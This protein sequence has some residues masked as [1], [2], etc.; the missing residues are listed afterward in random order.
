MRTTR[1]HSGNKKIDAIVDDNLNPDVH[2]NTNSDDPNDWCSTDVIARHMQK[3]K[4]AVEKLVGIECP[5]QTLPGLLEKVA[6]A[7]DGYRKK[8]LLV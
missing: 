5:Y 4:N 8:A 6:N 2:M 3:R 1:N 7:D